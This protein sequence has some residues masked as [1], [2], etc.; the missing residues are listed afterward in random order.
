[1]FQIPIDEIRYHV[2]QLSTE[3]MNWGENIYF[4]VIKKYDTLPDFIKQTTKSLNL[5]EEGRDKLIINVILAF[6]RY[7]NKTQEIKDE[8]QF[9]KIIKKWLFKFLPYIVENVKACKF[10][11]LCQYEPKNVITNYI[12]E[13]LFKEMQKQ[14]TEGF[15]TM[16]EFQNYYLFEFINLFRS[17]KSSQTLFFIGD[18]VHGV[19]LYRGIMEILS[20]LMLAEKFQEDYVK[21]KTYNLHLQIKKIYKVEMPKEVSEE[22]NS[23]PEYAKHKE[24]F[25]AYGWAKDS[26]GKRILTMKD[27]VKASG[28]YNENVQAWL[29]ISSE[30]VHEDYVGVGYDYV[31]M[32]FVIL[33]YYYFVLTHMIQ[34]E[35]FCIEI[36]GKKEMKKFKEIIEFVSLNVF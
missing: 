31:Y 5:K 6:S 13:R 21:F 28:F 11:H 19:A 12:Y 22:L 1:M 23:Y 7:I 25:L 16:S 18:D 17:L 2:N 10:T 15:E 8:Q 27:I 35:E 3:D 29:Q 36:M 9:L 30:F 4:N 32:R 33:N 24:A 20:K 26:K 34:T 14:H